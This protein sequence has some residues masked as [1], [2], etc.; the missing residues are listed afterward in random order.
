MQARDAASKHSLVLRGVSFRYPARRQVAV[1][2][3]LDLTIELGK[4]TALVGRSGSGKTTIAS[5]IAQLYSPEKGDVLL[6]DKP[7]SRFTKQAWASAVALVSQEPSLFTGTIADNIA[8]G[9]LGDCS[10][11]EVEAA[12][13]TANAHEFVQK[14]PQGYDTVVGPQGTLLSGGQ[15]QRIAVARA[16]IK[17]APILVLDEATSA[18]DAVSERLVQEALE[19]LEK[20]RT[21]EFGC[22]RGCGQG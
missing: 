10:R 11:E 15:R 9:R 16:L 22:E 4:V 12:S 14:L 6:G 5:L 21:G 2:E 17:D 19:R 7:V 13:R 3:G 20:G 8:Y 18:L 1:L